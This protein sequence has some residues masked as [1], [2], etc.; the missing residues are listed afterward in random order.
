MHSREEKGH[1]SIAYR[2]ETLETIQV[3]INKVKKYITYNEINPLQLHVIVWMN[4]SRIIL[5][6]KKSIKGNFIWINYRK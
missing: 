2:G 1:G 6:K 5:S 3:N 4:L